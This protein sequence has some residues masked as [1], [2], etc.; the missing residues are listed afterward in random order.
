[1][2]LTDNE[3]K[4]LTVGLFKQ[5]TDRDKQRKVGA[6]QISDPCTRHLAKA[7][8]AE[9]EPEIKY[10]L[11]GKIGTA[12]HSLLEHSI[13]NSDAD[14]LAD[15]L[16]EQKITLG[17]IDGYGIVSSKPDLV[18]PSVRHLID[19]K[20]SS[21][22]KVKKMQKVLDGLSEDA[23]TI[24]TLNKYV[25]QAQLY[26]WG[27]NNSGVP[28]DKV[29]L[30]FINRDG[31]YENDLWV[32]SVEYNEELANL[33]WVRVSNLWNELKCGKIPE[34]YEANSSCFK[35]SVGI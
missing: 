9:P 3:V 10:W 25:G 21:R 16:V 27:L 11:G 33:L 12:I 22:D 32:Y 31:T 20:T 14:L 6:S 35:C 24:Y 17:E 7:L 29:S 23:S 18:L 34:D 13:A 8:L 30:V 5:Q 28:V 19:W 2:S 15:A 4:A 26:A 1:M